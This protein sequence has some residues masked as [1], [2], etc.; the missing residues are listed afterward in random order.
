[1]AK[2]ISKNRLKK[3]AR[4]RRLLSHRLHKEKKEYELLLKSRLTYEDLTDADSSKAKSVIA[5]GVY[6]RKTPDISS[7]MSNRPISGTKKPSK[8]YSGDVVIGIATMHKSNGI[9]IISK[10]QAIDCATMRRN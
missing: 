6:R 3:L 2:K 1:M 5:S 8:K 7:H 9:P 10:E 4:E